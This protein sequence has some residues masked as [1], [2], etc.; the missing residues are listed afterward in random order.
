[1]VLSS[2]KWQSYFTRV[3][4]PKNLSG[5]FEGRLNNFCSNSEES[6]HEEFHE[7]RGLRIHSDASDDAV[8]SAPSLRTGRYRGSCG[9][10]CESPAYSG[11]AVSGSGAG[12]SESI[13]LQDAKGKGRFSE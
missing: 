2:L 6:S 8:A 10:E 9:A 13:C 5:S 12:D 7:V 11:D 3:S 4:F 1:M